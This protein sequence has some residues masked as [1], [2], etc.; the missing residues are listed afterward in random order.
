M[1]GLRGK[2]PAFATKVVQ[3]SG[4]Y[5]L[6]FLTS[7]A[8]AVV[9]NARHLR[10]ILF[11]VSVQMSGSASPAIQVIFFMKLDPKRVILFLLQ[12]F[13]DLL[14]LHL[15]K[16]V[17]LFLSCGKFCRATVQKLYLATSMLTSS[18]ISVTPNSFVTLLKKVLFFSTILCLLPYGSL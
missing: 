6:L 13:I 2:C 16:A 5:P 7:K 14:M 4:K 18:L 3:T 9:S 17:I 8:D 1:C 15:L 10:Q 11:F 12:Q